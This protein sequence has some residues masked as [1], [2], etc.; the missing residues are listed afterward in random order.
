MSFSWK[1][2][3]AAMLA[4]HFEIPHLH[5]MLMHEDQ[6]IMLFEADHFPIRKADGGPDVFWNCLSRWRREHREKTAKIDMPDMA[7]ERRVRSSHA[8]HLRRMAAKEPGKDTRELSR[9][10]QRRTRTQR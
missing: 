1:T 4:L 2:K 9:K 8:D 7:H 10:W 6:I 5:Q 3:Y